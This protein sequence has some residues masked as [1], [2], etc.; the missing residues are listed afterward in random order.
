MQGWS[1]MAALAGVVGAVLLCADAALADGDETFV[2]P[3]VKLT[4]RIAGLS[5]E[6]CDVEIKPG[7]PGCRFETV[8]RHVSARGEETVLLRDVQCRNADRDCSFRITVNEPGQSPSTV[9]RGFQLAAPDP[10]RPSPTPSFAC[11]INAPSKVARADAERM[12]AEAARMRAEV[13]RTR[14]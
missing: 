3:K 14:R 1:R 6:G 4:L 9:R 8:T 13:E 10:D 11:F 12:R 7:H 2:V 5:N